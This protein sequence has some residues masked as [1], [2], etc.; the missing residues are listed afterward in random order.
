MKMKIGEDGRPLS[1]VQLFRTSFEPGNIHEVWL[2]VRCKMLTAAD[3]A[4]AV[5]VQLQVRQT[6]PSSILH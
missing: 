1:S 4:R 6:L 3:P 2:E 5:E